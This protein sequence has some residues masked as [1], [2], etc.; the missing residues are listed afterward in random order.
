MEYIVGGLLALVTCIA[1]T[2][3]GFDRSRS[4]YPV[5]MIV[6]ASYYCLFAVIGGSRTALWYD[7]AIALLFAGVAVIGFR[8]TQWLVVAALAAH[9]GMDLVHHHLVANAGV[10]SWW[11]G[12]CAAFDVI[13]A[14]YLAFNLLRREDLRRPT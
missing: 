3:I 7:L 12:F 2:L 8:T 1:V 5:I 9:G 11:P 6:I 13:A 14:G 10:P 4:F